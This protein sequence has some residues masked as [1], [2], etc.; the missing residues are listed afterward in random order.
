MGYVFLAFMGI[1]GG[2]AMLSAI[3]WWRRRWY[4]RPLRILASGDVAIGVVGS[5]IPRRDLL[6]IEA[7]RGIV[8]YIEGGYQERIMQVRLTFMANGESQRLILSEQGGEAHADDRMAKQLAERLG[9][10]LTQATSNAPI[11]RHGGAES[12]AV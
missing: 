1:L 12:G 8:G 5:V 2:A 11:N 7:V 10:A 4:L 3:V 6:E 9:I